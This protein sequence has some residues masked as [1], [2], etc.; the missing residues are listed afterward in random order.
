MELECKYLAVNVFGKSEYS[1][2]STLVSAESPDKPKINSI[3]SLPNKIRINYSLGSQ[4]GY[5]TSKVEIFVMAFNGSFFS[6]C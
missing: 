6:V 5:L 3:T 4:N 1:S 2:S